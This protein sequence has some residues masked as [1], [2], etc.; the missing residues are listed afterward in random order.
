VSGSPNRILVVDDNPATLYATGRVLKAAGFEVLTATTG[1][2]A[3]NLACE[4]VPDL[5]VL[6]VNLPDFDG[7][8]VVRRVR[9]VPILVRV[10]II[11]LSATF[12]QD[13]YKV[14]GLEGGANG[15]LTHPVEPP[16]LVASINAFLRTKQAEDA[17]RRSEDRFKAVFERALDGIALVNR[18]LIFVDINPAMCR[19]LGR[20][21]DEI[22]GKHASALSVKGYEN[23]IGHIAEMIARDGVWRGELPLLKADGS[24][25]ELEWSVSRH[26]EPDLHLA[27]VTDVTQRRASELERERLLKR[28]S[29]AR[30]EAERANRL[31]DDFLAMLSHELRSPLNAI[32]GWTQVLQRRSSDESFR[33]E[34]LADALSVIERNARLQTQLISDLL[35]VSRITSGKLRIEIAPLDPAGPLEAAIDGVRPAAEAR[36]IRLETEIDRLAGP[37]LG[38]PSRLQQVFWNLLNNAVKFT[39]QGGTVWARLAREGSL[40]TVSVRDTGCGIEPEFVPFVFERF[41]QEQTTAQRSYGGLGLGLTIV[42]HL[43]EMHGGTVAAASEGRGLGATFTVSLPLSDARHQRRATGPEDVTRGSEPQPDLHGLRV[44]VVDDDDDARD[45]LMR[46]LSDRGAEV[47]GA[48]TAAQALELVVRISP[49]VLVSDIGMPKEDGLALI[50]KLRER[51]FVGPELH[52]IAVTALARAEDRQK[53]LAAGYDGF[54][55]KPVDLDAL[56]ESVAS[57]GRSRAAAQGTSSPSGIF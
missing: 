31:K 39:P 23:H 11:H 45:L 12:V 9:A 30:S 28:E 19:T 54:F 47:H 34:E 32:V 25:V 50:R 24:R 6:D 26:S 7:F 53:S 42:R 43:V 20:T 3:V 57:V 13:A 52:A 56:V 16:V 41:R 21:R 40:V 10:P 1:S 4:F 44:L 29:D 5:I 49:R 18:G 27:I 46:V 38:D 15:Y 55:V 36:R 37:V 22:I 51:G 8:E 48:A 2:D 33:K 17:M 35:D 14:L